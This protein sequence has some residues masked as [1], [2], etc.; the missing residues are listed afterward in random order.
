M[1][2]NEHEDLNNDVSHVMRNICYFLN[3]HFNEDVSL[4]SLSKMF[5]LH[6]CTISRAFTKYY[7]KNFTT[8]LNSIRISHSIQLLEKT[9]MSITEISE[10]SGYRSINTFLRRFN[11]AMGISPLQYRH[12][13]Q[14]M[15][16][17]INN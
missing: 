1:E 3:E 11:I 10:K 5:Y 15:K 17:S 8:Y 2:L 4:D 6:P 12:N 9:N 7:A 16:R 14:K 13:Y